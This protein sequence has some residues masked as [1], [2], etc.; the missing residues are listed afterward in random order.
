[1]STF[2]ALVTEEV[3]ANRLLSLS[4][5]NGVPKISVTSAGGTPD[6]RSTGPISEG[7]EVTVKLQNNPVWKVE[8][9]EDLSA[10]TYVEVGEGGVLVASDG[11]GIGYVAEAT[12]DGGVAKLVRKAG[13]GAGTPGPKG[14]KGDKGDTGAP[15]AKGDKGDKGDPGEDG[16]PTEAQWDDLVGRVEVLEG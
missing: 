9:G 14:D 5:G 7:A 8:V 16:F 4:G 12:E 3:K 2:K 6:F 10:G 13:G 1:M 15:G 11:E